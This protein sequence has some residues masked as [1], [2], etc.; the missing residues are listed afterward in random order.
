MMK[1]VGFSDASPSV[2]STRAA[3]LVRG[4]MARCVASRL[5]TSPHLTR[6]ARSATPPLLPT[7]VWTFHCALRAR[8]Q[9]AIVFLTLPPHRML[10]PLLPSCLSHPLST[11]CYISTVPPP[12][13]VRLVFRPDYPVVSSP[14][15]TLSRLSPPML[16]PSPSAASA[17]CAPARQPSAAVPYLLVVFGPA[18]PSGR[19]C[20][21]CFA[22]RWWPAPARL[23]ASDCCFLCFF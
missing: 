3:R 4:R 9:L 5:Q 12:S 6:W 22:T 8:S 1:N 7:A 15:C 19:A 13:S 14:L 17:P 2:T 16:L 10:T 20:L 21:Y 18:F 11:C 23:P